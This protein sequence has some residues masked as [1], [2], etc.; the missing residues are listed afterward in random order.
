[1]GAD[2]TTLFAANTESTGF[3][4]YTLSVNS[5]GVT[6]NRDFQS[7]FGSFAN[8]IHFDTGTKL[9]Y[10]EEGHVI[11]PATG[12]PTGNFNASGPMVMDST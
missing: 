10:A 9:I 4:F 6:Q 7:V 8:R 3:D 11:N 5:G 2:A 1:M 12:L